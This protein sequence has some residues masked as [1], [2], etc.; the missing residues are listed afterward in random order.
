MVQ[1]RLKGQKIEDSKRSERGAS[2]KVQVPKAMAVVAMT[3]S[4]CSEVYH[5]GM[6]DVEVVAMEK[7]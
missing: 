7:V 2:E 1:Y 4:C 5:E 6:E 3:A